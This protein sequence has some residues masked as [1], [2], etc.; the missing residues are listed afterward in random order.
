MRTIERLPSSIPGASQIA[1]ITVEILGPVPTEPIRVRAAV[2][3]SGR[4]V[5]L[6]EAELEAAGRLAIRARAWRIRSA[7]LALPAMPDVPA[8]P[9]IPTDRTFQPPWWSSGYIEAVDFRFVSGDFDQRGPAAAWTRIRHPLLPDEEPSPTQRLMAVAD[10]GNGLSAMLDVRKW[11]FIN[12]ELTV[13][14]IRPP[15]G[16]WIY[17]DARTTLDRSGVGLAETDLYDTT[18]RVGRGAQSLMV[19]PRFG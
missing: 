7:D 17:V 14:L 19:G 1:R 9:P 10:S 4:A 3:R 12:T 15:A 2:A 11:W 18:G 8:P 13:H 5:E 6:V 16:E